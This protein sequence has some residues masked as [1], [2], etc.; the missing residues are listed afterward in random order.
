[1]TDYP[2]YHATL[3]INSAL[4]R[5]MFD[6]VGLDAFSGGLYESMG[7]QMDTRSG[8]GMQRVHPVNGII[9]HIANMM[10]QANA[11]NRK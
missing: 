7:G 4:R 2:R 1:M 3:G 10:Q 9:E 8:V 5:S 6:P 11:R